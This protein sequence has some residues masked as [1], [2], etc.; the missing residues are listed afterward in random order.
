MDYT[1]VREALRATFDLDDTESIEE[2][3]DMRRD[4]HVEK[5]MDWK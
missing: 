1:L 2:Y 4:K 5:N 3:Q